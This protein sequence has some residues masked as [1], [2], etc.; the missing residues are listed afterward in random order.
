MELL[1]SSAVLLETLGRLH[2]SVGVDGDGL[3]ITGPRSAMTPD[4]E[5]AIRAHAP[6]ILA[7]M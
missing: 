1:M 7:A 2:L 3:R 5:R 6:A 4:L